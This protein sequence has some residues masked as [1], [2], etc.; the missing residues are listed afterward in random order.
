MGEINIEL[1]FNTVINV[2][3]SLVMSWLLYSA[4][5]NI[6]FSNHTL[7]G[8]STFVIIFILFSVISLRFGSGSLKY[9][10]LFCVI[11]SSLAINL[12]VTLKTPIIFGDE[13]Y[14]AGIAERISQ[15]Q[16]M[17]RYLP[18]GTDAYKW[19]LT[20]APLYFVFLASLFSLGGEFLV[21]FNGPILASMAAMVLFVFLRRNYS[22]LAGIL[23]PLF[24]LSFPSFITYTV[25]FY[26]HLYA[27]VMFLSSVIF[28]Q[29]YIE[30]KDVRFLIVS[31]T[32]GGMSMLTHQAGI[33]LIFLYLFSY[34]YQQWGSRRDLLIAFSFFTIVMGSF[35]IAYSLPITGSLNVPFVNRFVQLVIQPKETRIT[36]I[37]IPDDISV[38]PLAPGPGGGVQENIF[39][40]NFINYL[41]FAYSFRYFIIAILGAGYLLIDNKKKDKFIVFWLL[42]LGLM[43]LYAGGI[44]TGSAETFGRALLFIAPPLAACAAIAIYKIYEFV[45]EASAGVNERYRLFGYGMRVIGAAIIVAFFMASFF[46]S[47]QANAKAASLVPIKQFSKGFFEGCDWVRAN[48]PEDSYILTIWSSRTTY[49]CK[50]LTTWSTLPD[51]PVMIYTLD[52]RSPERMKIHGIDYVYIQKFSVSREKSGETYSL[53]FVQFLDT[54]KEW[55]EKVYENEDVILYQVK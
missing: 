12:N 48:T 45:Q 15:Q 34:F 50:R 40:M 8:I 35:Y 13:G 52:E 7:I 14:Y 39:K 10:F 4:T 25:L 22:P 38:P 55:F 16:A 51:L 44:T 36:L 47:G 37:E 19:I 30:N 42:V 24:L 41:E 49:A 1:N 17:Q 33:L 3:G 6:F 9:I 23:A 31:A 26:N 29:K 32:L 27:V 28:L 54:R 18:Q 21:K 20:D 11:A 53:E 43:I 5:G 2:L 46:P